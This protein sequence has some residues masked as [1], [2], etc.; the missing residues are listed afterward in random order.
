MATP[1]RKEFGKDKVMLFDEVFERCPSKGLLGEPIV[2]I[3]MEYLTVF[4]SWT[5]EQRPRL[6]AAREPAGCS[7]E[8]AHTRI[9]SR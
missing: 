9:C 5:S 7:C 8:M 3:G 1:W 6:A 4:R 2:V